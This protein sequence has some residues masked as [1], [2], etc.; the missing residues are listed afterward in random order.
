MTRQVVLL[1]WPVGHSLSPV[2]QEAAFASLGLDWRYSAVAVRPQHLARVLADLAASPAVVGANVTLPHKTAV[3]RYLPP[4]RPVAGAAGAANTLVRDRLDPGRGGGAAAGRRGDAGAGGPAAVGRPV[5]F[6]ADNTDVEGFLGCLERA[7]FAAGG[8]RCVILG[9]GG[10]ARACAVALAGVGASE[11]T[12]VGRSAARAAQL[13]GDLRASCRETAAV[14]LEAR[15]WTGFDDLMTAGGTPE[16]CR[17]GQGARPPLL[18]HATPVGMWPDVSTSP[19]SQAQV[20]R[21]P[22]GTQVVDLVYRPRTTRLMTMAAAA[23]LPAAGGQEMLVCQGSASLSLW[24]GE[25]V[26]AG[27]RNA[28][29]QA[30]HQ[31]LTREEGTACYGC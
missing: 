20:E 8:A 21:L 9:T 4:G 25:P 26:D 31:A 3:L 18:I 30:L 14:R 29:R 6:V 16:R 28:M 13:A 22:A 23:G 15:D 24:L 1:G 27:V 11:I 2:M 17:P 19:L 5:G 12:L 7:A 10:A